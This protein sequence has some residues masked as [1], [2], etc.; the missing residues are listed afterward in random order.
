M[1]KAPLAA[2]LLLVS[3]GTV[4]QSMDSQISK[5]MELP[6]EAKRIDCISRV[7]IGAAT[8]AL[9]HWNVVQEVDAMTDQRQ[10][11]VRYGDAEGDSLVL[12]WLPKVSATIRGQ[13]YPGRDLEAR[14]DRLP[15]IVGKAGVFDEQQSRAIIADAR[16][17]E[18]ILVRY[19]VWPH[20]KF[21]ERSVDL[22]GFADAV[23]QCERYMRG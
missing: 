17:G 19:V 20:A 14:V 9:D 15:R 12:A 4:A 7:D 8:T 6:E 16:R 21:V 3:T 22:Q 10:C 5:C 1:Y 11:F 2:A 18:S 13:L 23:D